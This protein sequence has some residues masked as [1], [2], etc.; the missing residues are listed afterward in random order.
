VKNKQVTTKR[1]RFMCLPNP[2]KPKPV[3]QTVD[4]YKLAMVLRGT[5]WLR[6]QSG[7]YRNTGLRPMDYAAVRH[8]YTRLGD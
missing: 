4:S 8:A 2:P 1:G 6:T 3:L 7:A 5:I